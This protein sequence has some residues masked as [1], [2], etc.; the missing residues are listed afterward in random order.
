MVINKLTYATVSDVA[1]IVSVFFC[2]WLK[3]AFFYMESFW[4][5]VFFVLS[6]YLFYSFK[7]CMICAHYC[8]EYPVSDFQFLHY[9]LLIGRG[10]EQHSMQKLNLSH[11]L[12]V[13]FYVVCHCDAVVVLLILTFIP[14]TAQ[15]LWYDSNSS[16]GD[17]VFG[18][19]HVVQLPNRLAVNTLYITPKEEIERH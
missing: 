10:T 16:C 7:F 1:F 6:F 5:V 15:H 2:F 18:F 9:N 14:Y 12:L 8:A 4:C 19:H 13:N 17:L 3:H 11:F